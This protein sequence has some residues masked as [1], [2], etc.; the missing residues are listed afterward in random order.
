MRSVLVG[1]ALL[2]FVNAARAGGTADAQSCLS[3]RDM[4]EI[5]SSNSVVAPAQAIRQARRAVP[6]AD[7]LR[8]NLCRGGEAL[9]YVITV[10][11]RDGRVVHVTVDAPSGKVAAVQ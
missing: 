11:R 6:G 5:V 7:M 4:Q 9:V 1:L 10:L 2:G 8:A 3:A